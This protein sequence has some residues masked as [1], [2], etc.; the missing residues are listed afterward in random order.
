MEFVKG[1]KIADVLAAVH[2][3]P[4]L[5][6]YGDENTTVAEA[7][8]LLHKHNFQSL[9]IIANDLSKVISLFFVFSFVFLLFF[10]FRFWDLWM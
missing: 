7:L 4:Q 6:I 8:R 2:K 9:P 5:V 10:S 3:A 1:K